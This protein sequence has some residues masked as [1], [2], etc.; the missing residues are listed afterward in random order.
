MGGNF[1][2]YGAGIEW[3]GGSSQLDDE[4][5]YPFE[6]FEV[7]RWASSPTSGHHGSGIE[8]A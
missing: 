5:L 8:E 7:E 2:Y 3:R 4:V 6:V 1:L